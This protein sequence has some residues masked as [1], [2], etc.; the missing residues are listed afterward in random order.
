MDTENVAYM[1]N[2]VLFT[3]KRKKSCYLQQHEWILR[4]LCQ[5]AKSDRER[6]VLYYLTYVEFKKNNKKLNSGTE[7]RLMF[8]RGRE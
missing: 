6:Q 8:V 2:E 1:Y 7:N 3:L 5:I 4:A